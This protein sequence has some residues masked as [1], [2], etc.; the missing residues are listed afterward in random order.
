MTMTAVAVGLGLLIWPTRSV[1]GRRAAALVL[2]GRLPPVPGVARRA[3]PVVSLPLG[4]A[5]TLGVAGWL[6]GPALGV[7]VTA[8]GGAVLLPVKAAR[9]AT[10]QAQRTADLLVA[11]TL[12][13]AEL[14]AGAGLPDALATA[15]LHAGSAVAD[16][17]FDPAAGERNR[18]FTAAATV[19]AA[20]GVPWAAVVAGLARDVG[21]ADRQHREVDTVLSGVRA[22]MLL[23][24][25]LPLLGLVMAA[26]LGADPLQFLLRTPGGQVDLAAGATLLFL[27]VAW[28]GR[29][30]GR[31]VP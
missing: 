17:R 16:L 29:I 18:A 21:A 4:G 1:S 9:R 7:A 31:A 8:G 23:L 6:L 30:T 13:R 24:A 12:L 14:E 2:A 10:I 11:L 19:V 25:G 15:R 22:S 20:H 3:W 26:G 28:T 5:A 27:G